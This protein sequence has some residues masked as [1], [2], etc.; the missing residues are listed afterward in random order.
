MTDEMT[1][2]TKAR[3]LSLYDE[4]EMSEHAARELLGDDAFDVAM[5]KARGADM[6]LSGDPSRFLTD[7][8]G[9]AR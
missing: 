2:A 5:Q 7:G 9:D 8:D 1:D 3:I 6:M 4:G